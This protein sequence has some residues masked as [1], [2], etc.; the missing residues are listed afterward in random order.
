MIAAGAAA[1]GRQ[2]RWPGGTVHGRKPE[3]LDEILDCLAYAQAVHQGDDESAL[4]ASDVLHLRLA[5]RADAMVA[6]PR[7]ARLILDEAERQG[8][9]I[10]AVLAGAPPARSEAAVSG[11]RCQFI[12]ACALNQ[13]LVQADFLTCRDLRNL[14]PAPARPPPRGLLTAGPCHLAPVR[15]PARDVIYPAAT[16]IRAGAAAT[17]GQS[18]DVADEQLAVAGGEDLQGRA[19]DPRTGLPVDLLGPD[20]EQ[21]AAGGHVQAG[22][23]D[24]QGIVP[25]PAPRRRE[26][27]WPGRTRLPARVASPSSIGPG[28]PYRPARRCGSARCGPRYCARSAARSRP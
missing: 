9:D 7:L 28:K 23:H 20:A 18:G 22:L 21:L 17:D 13:L 6:P 14:T 8:R 2:D 3:P 1:A 15:A 10:D 19:A 12:S 5:G 26:S 25:V 27:L 11:A 4:A 16:D 24:R